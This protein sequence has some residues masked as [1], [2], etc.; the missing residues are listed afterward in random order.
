MEF[1]DNLSI[2]VNSVEKLIVRIEKSL[3][4]QNS[5]AYNKDSC[6]EL[7]VNLIDNIHELKV[8]VTKIQI[9]LEDEKKKLNQFK[10]SYK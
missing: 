1:E 4:I 3:K 6:K 10:V 7:Y 2:Y 9:I 8:L 5:L